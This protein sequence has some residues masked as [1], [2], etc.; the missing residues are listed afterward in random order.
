MSGLFR[1]AILLPILDCVTS[2]FAGLVIFVYLGYMAHVQ[3]TTV[4]DVVTQGML[5][6]GTV[7]KMSVS[8]PM[9]REAVWSSGKALGW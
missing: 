6:V 2:V 9:L 8:V 1:D 7:Y 5:C 3:Q 4:D